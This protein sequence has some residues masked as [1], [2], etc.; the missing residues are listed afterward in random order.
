MMRLNK[1]TKREA[2]RKISDG[3]RKKSKVRSVLDKNGFRE[4]R[5]EEDLSPWLSHYYV[6]EQKNNRLIVSVNDIGSK[7][8]QG[9]RE[10]FAYSRDKGD[11][12]SSE[13]KE[14]FNTKYVRT[15]QFKNTIISRYFQSKNFEKYAARIEQKLFH[16]PESLKDSVDLRF[17]ISQSF[18]LVAYNSRNNEFKVMLKSED[19][20]LRM[21]KIPTI[22]MK[23]ECLESSLRNKRNRTIRGFWSFAKYDQE[24]ADKTVTCTVNGHSSEESLKMHL[25]TIAKTLGIG[26]TIKLNNHELGVKE[27]IVVLNE[28]KI[29]SDVS[30][31][32]TANG[33]SGVYKCTF[34]CEGRGGLLEQERLQRK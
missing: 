1:F 30:Y 5:G 32:S 29:T 31:S 24:I 23:A 4:L 13:A 3:V 26:S 16:S 34:Q 28:R 8:Q 7:K 10:L 18:K 6:I 9:L 33:S 21:S 27:K 25:S 20:T 22:V 17:L 11:S 14:I 19:E 12:L 2:G 15:P